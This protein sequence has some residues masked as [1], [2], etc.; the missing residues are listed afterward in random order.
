MFGR[1][2]ALRALDEPP[3]APAERARAGE[4]VA[5]PP[6]RETR[7]AM[8]RHAGLERD[9]EGL[10]PLLDDPHPLARLVAR[11]ALFREE[12]RGAHA[13][14]DFPE[15]DP[16]LDDRH[17]VLAAEAAEPRLEHWA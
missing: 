3:A 17:T 14:A 13:R 16:A 1:R 6:T 8:W 9:A 11:S 5:P 12:S 15:T 2:A 7:K 4:A 10:R